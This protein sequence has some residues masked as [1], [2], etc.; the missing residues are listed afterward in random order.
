ME[1][2]I[3]MWW[4]EV[5]RGEMA[6]AGAEVKRISIEK[7]NFQEGIPA[8]TAICD[9]GWSKRTHKH[10]YNAYGGVG[11]IFGAET[12]KL[13]CMGKPPKNKAESIVTAKNV[14]CIGTWAEPQK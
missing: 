14:A 4:K 7:G 3:G 5:V 10:S 8:V 2:Q 11:V 9:G 12:K 13:L 6:K 1:D